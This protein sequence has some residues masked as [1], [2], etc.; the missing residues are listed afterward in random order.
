MIPT[1]I[2]LRRYP[3][4]PITV[5]L[6][7]IVIGWIDSPSTTQYLLLLAPA[8]AQVCADGHA[9]VRLMGAAPIELPG[10]SFEHIIWTEAIEIAVLQFLDVGII[11]LPYDP[12]ALGKCGLKLIQNM[13]Y[14]LPVVASP[15][16]INSEI[17]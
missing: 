2:K 4:K 5:G 10:V 13:A 17:V 16:G 15:V 8:L 14:G 11:P 3:R 7:P 6:R 12:W 1:V 9:M